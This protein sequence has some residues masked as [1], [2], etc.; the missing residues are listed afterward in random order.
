MLRLSR[1]PHEPLA[2]FRFLSF[3]LAEIL[4]LLN[5]GVFAFFTGLDAP[6]RWGPGLSAL[7][8]SAWW[9]YGYRR[10][11]FP[12]AGWLVDAV[13]VA[14]VAAWSPMPLRSIGLFYAG[15]Q[16]R[17]LFVPRREL[18]LLPLTYGA[19]RFASFF[20]GPSREPLSSISSTS[21]MQIVGLSVIAVTLYLFAEAT[22]RHGEIEQ[23]LK[24]S[25]ERYRLVAS[26]TRDAIYDLDVVT[27]EVHWTESIHSVFGYSPGEANNTL[28]WWL[29]RIH[30]ADRS[31]VEKA[32]AEVLE[33]PGIRVRTVTCRL[34]RGD[35]TYAHVAGTMLV[36][37][38][39][40]G[41]PRRIVGSVRDVTAERQLEEQLRQSQK[42]D[43][44]GQLAGG[45]AHDFNN[46]LT[47]IGGHVYMLEKAIPRSETVERHLGGIVRAS[48]RA[49][50]LTKQLLAFGRRQMLTPKALDVNGVVTDV[51]EL[52]RPV[53]GEHILIVTHLA[54]KTPVVFA[55]AGQLSQVL[56]NL[57]LNARDAMP[58]GGTLTIETGVAVV[59]ASAETSGEHLKPGD[60]VKLVVR[61]TGTGMDA[62]TLDRAFEPFFTTKRG[63][64]S[65]LG[66]ATVYGI[67]KQSHGDIHAESAPGAGSTFTILLPA[68]E[69][70]VEEPV[71]VHSP[72]AQSNGGD[73]RNVLLVEDDPEVRAFAEEVL[74][75]AG[76]RVHAARNGLDALALIE[77]R[78][79]PVDLVVT[80]VVMPEMGGRDMMDHLH[81]SRPNLP[82]LY[83]T[84]YT[85]DR[86]MLGALA[87]ADERMLA[88]PFTAGMLVEAVKS[89]G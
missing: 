28:Q 72:V 23:A 34:R 50:L 87:E 44:I 66:L 10:R 51:V 73:S 69:E 70:P 8:L 5:I 64:G 30:P 46:L 86:R 18:P 7:A 27:G 81:Q 3:W 57:A 2:R 89:V 58:D 56:V 43:A 88:K 42:M 67:V 47:V 6:Y 83:M 52:I 82:V 4:M 49:A 55:D 85:D 60:Y 13:L 63:L 38:N 17:A 48:E 26:A 12:I 71:V 53:I 35:D 75:N 68:S 29:D 54:S 84:G 20:I 31:T 79:W 16:F 24:Q 59:S 14:V 11:G 78:K 76:Y 15:V 22:R 61:D 40:G 1:F 9:W 62:A 33:N 37:R 39:A 77:A 65:G 74:N 25:D 21:A 32:L 36:Q 19:A 41:A 80:D 45:V